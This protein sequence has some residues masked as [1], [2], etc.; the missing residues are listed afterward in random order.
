[1]FKSKAAPAE[2]VVEAEK[3]P[4]VEEGEVVD[5][6]G[7]EEE[8]SVDEDELERAKAMGVLTHDSDSLRNPCHC[9]DALFAIAWGICFLAS[10][11]CC[12]EYGWTAMSE[13]E[14]DDDDEKKEEAVGNLAKVLIAQF[15]V[16]L[17]IAEVGLFVMFTKYAIHCSLIF[18]EV[19][20]LLSAAFAAHYTYWYTAMLFAFLALCCL[21]FQTN[22][23]RSIQNASATLGVACKFLRSQPV[24]II[25][26]FAGSFVAMLML[27]VCAL[28]VFAVYHYK[29]S[30]K[31][32][33][34]S[35]L[36][37]SMLLLILIFLW[38]ARVTKYVTVVVTA[39]TAKWWWSNEKP[40][41]RPAVTAFFRTW[42]FFFG[43][44]CFGA[45]FVDL[46]DFAMMILRKSREWADRYPN[47]LCASCLVAWCACCLGACQGACDVVNSYAFVFVGVHGY[48][49]LYSGKQVIAVFHKMGRK[50]NETEIFAD[51]VLFWQSLAVGLAAAVFG[52][53]MVIHGS[54]TLS[55]GTNKAEVIVAFIGFFGGMA[56][57]SVVFALITGANKAI[58]LQFSDTPR[59]LALAHP[60]EFATLAT[61][62]QLGPTALGGPSYGAMDD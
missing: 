37:V 32:T 5:V 61:V 10:L 42:M 12:F 20:L 1:M 14:Y 43:S 59:V 24:L 39:G 17:G 34:R 47:G 25:L 62:W 7:A 33:D 28:A 52:L 56:V 3:P 55:S 9:P 22:S 49:F 48:S 26:A 19:I 45:L 4:S 38:T 53:Y 57:A 16:A 23:L 30:K 6:E 50:A 46:F 44:V 35:G 27:F 18:T 40:A 8:K 11:M 36:S 41:G 54:D 60:D 15:C 31:N 58:T 13:A 21:L 29:I 2:V 51:Y